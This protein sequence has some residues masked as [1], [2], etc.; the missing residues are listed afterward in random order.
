MTLVYRADESKPAVLA[1]VTEARRL[2]PTQSPT[3][4]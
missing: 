2:A 4:K 3:I 1:F